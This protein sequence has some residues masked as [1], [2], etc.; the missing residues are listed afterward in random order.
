VGAGFAA[1]AWPQLA[2]NKSVG[3]PPAAAMA[4]D[5]APHDALPAL[6]SQV[7]PPPPPSPPPP[8]AAACRCAHAARL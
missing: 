4:A 5:G 6:A 7:R 8:I 2:P 1:R 3:N